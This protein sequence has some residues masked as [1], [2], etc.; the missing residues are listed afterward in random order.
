MLILS[1]GDLI[2]LHSK[3][4]VIQAA[5]EV[6][7]EIA[8]QLG[9]IDSAMHVFRSLSFIQMLIYQRICNQTLNR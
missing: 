7:I 4:G 9:A 1:C 6:G 3:N 2:E 5:G 8:M